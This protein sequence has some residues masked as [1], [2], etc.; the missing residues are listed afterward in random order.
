MDVAQEREEAA[1]LRGEQGHHVRFH[2]GVEADAFAAGADQDGARAGALDDARGL[3]TLI[4][5]GDIG[6]VVGGVDLVP[7][8]RRQ[9]LG[10][11]DEP[12]ARQDLDGGAEAAADLAAPRSGRVDHGV[13]GHHRTVG[14]ANSG[15]P[16]AGSGDRGD[17]FA[18]TDPGAAP[19]GGPQ[20]SGGG[21]DGL[22]LGVLRIVDATGEAGGDVGFE[23]ADT[24]DA[25]G[26]DADCRLACGERVQGGET[27]G[28][29]RDDQAALVLELDRLRAQ[30][31]ARLVPEV[32]AEPGQLQLRAGLLVG[33]QDRSPP[34]GWWCPRRRGP[35]RAP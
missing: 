21:E 24:V 13:G 31:L 19:D 29:A 11:Q 14:R 5:G 22:H 12:P 33:E 3:Q 6:D 4:A 27:F 2:R 15:D 26:A 23:L 7:D 32:T 16:P 35:G 8:H 10:D 1:R 18:G 9:R 25:F 17:G 30:F 28:G 20:Q 34:P